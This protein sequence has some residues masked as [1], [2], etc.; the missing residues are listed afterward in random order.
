[1]DRNQT[2]KSDLE[3]IVVH[4]DRGWTPENMT[5]M[6]ELSEYINILRNQIRVARGRM[7]TFA[8]KSNML[9]L[10]VSTFT[11]QLIRILSG[12]QQWFFSAELEYVVLRDMVNRKVTSTSTMVGYRPVVTYLLSGDR[13]I[14][15]FGEKMD[16][17]ESQVQRQMEDMCG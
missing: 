10:H 14:K 3:I 8:V 16:E 5:N 1:M 9:R 13:A 17:Y 4:P 7:V 12:A 11:K 15:E 2:T 6:D